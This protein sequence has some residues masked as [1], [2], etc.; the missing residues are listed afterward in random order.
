MIDALRTLQ[1]RITAAAPP[2]T[3]SVEVTR[4]LADLAAR[5]EPHTVGEREQITGHLVKLPGRGQTMAPVLHIDE[6][7]D[8]HTRGRATFGRFY[9]G[10]NGAVHGGA[11]PLLFDEIMGR[12]AN[13]GGRRPSRT[14]Y[15]HVD[16]RSIAPAETELR[17]EARFDREEGRKRFLTGA[18]YHGNTLCAEAEGLFV[19]LRPGQ[20]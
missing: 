2:R 20:P 17:V 19:A 13:S 4:T 10:G 18:I 15:L 16:Y 3:S 12:L 11:V 7:D 9:L 6:R 1:D 14:A 8:N 5:L